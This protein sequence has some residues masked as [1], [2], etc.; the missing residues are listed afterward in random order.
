[1]SLLSVAAKF[2]DLSTK[3]FLTVL[4]TIFVVLLS[5]RP[6]QLWFL[7]QFRLSPEKKNSA[8]VRGN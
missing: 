3:I 7:T 6:V 1:M 8:L 2:G 5:S 4:S